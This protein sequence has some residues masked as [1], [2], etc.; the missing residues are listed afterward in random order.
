M[1]ILVDVAF[2]VKRLGELE[3]QRDKHT[4]VLEGTC[5]HTHVHKKL[6]MA[7]A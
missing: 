7:V 1:I 4:L 6:R 3:D 2:Y 5:I